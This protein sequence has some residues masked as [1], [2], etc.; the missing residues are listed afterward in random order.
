MNR[1]DQRH[2]KVP[3][4]SLCFIG[5]NFAYAPSVLRISCQS[6]IHRTQVQN[7]HGSFA[8]LR[9]SGS[10]EKKTNK[11]SKFLLVE[12]LSEGSVQDEHWKGQCSQFGHQL[13]SEKASD[14]MWLLHQAV[15]AP[16]TEV[17]EKRELFKKKNIATSGE[18]RGV[19]SRI[20][21]GDKFMSKNVEKNEA[22][23]LPSDL[24]FGFQVS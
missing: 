20:S 18:N 5:W 6:S 8:H 21:C 10:S 3:L 2:S 14:E 7:K 24:A 9:G 1:I 15:P 16:R 13:R 23:H 12:N 11:K 22:E 4:D 17:H 19:L